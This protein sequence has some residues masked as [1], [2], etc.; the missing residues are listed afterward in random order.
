MVNAIEAS[1]VIKLSP[2]EL[3]ARILLLVT[4]VVATHQLPLGN[5]EVALV[6]K[7]LVDELLG[8]GPLQPLIDDPMVSD[9]MV[10]GPMRFTSRSWVN[11]KRRRSSFA[12]KSSCS[13]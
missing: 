5:R 6:V 8:L 13:T 11:C 12:V 2:Q 3:E 10:N 4:D 9:I 7:Q 1:V